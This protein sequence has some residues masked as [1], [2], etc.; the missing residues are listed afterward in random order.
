MVVAEHHIAP[1]VLRQDVLEADRA[2]EQRDGILYFHQDA[3][4]AVQL[5]APVPLRYVLRVEAAHLL[6]LP[7]AKQRPLVLLG[8]QE[9]SEPVQVE[10]LPPR[11]T[12]AVGVLY[13]TRLQCYAQQL[14]VADAAHG[15][16]LQTVGEATGMP[17]NL[18]HPLAQQIGQSPRHAMLH[19]RCGGQIEKGHH[20][21]DALHILQAGRIQFPLESKE[22]A[23]HQRIV[24]RLQFAAQERHVQAGE[25]RDALHLRLQIAE[26]PIERLHLGQLAAVAQ[27]LEQR[28]QGNVLHGIQFV[29]QPLVELRQQL[30]TPDGRL[31]LEEAHGHDAQFADRHLVHAAGQIQ[32]EVEHLE[33][34]STQQ[35]AQEHGVHQLLRRQLAQP[36]AQLL[37]GQPHELTD[38][39]QTQAVPGVA[40]EQQLFAG[41]TLDAATAL[42]VHGV[43]Q[44]HVVARF[45]RFRRGQHGQGAQRA[46]QLVVREAMQ[47]LAVAAG[48][49]I[50]PGIAD[51]QVQ[52]D[53]V[54]HQALEVRI[55]F[56]WC[57]VALWPHEALGGGQIPPA[58][59]TGRPQDLVGFRGVHQDAVGELIFAVHKD[60]RLRSARGAQLAAQATR[61]APEAV[62]LC[63]HGFQLNCKRNSINLS[64]F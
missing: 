1:I 3:I 4:G 12:A 59:V 5:E 9:T 19:S 48:K 64:D 17:Q 36:A 57:G 45:G 30:W 46:Q 34:G 37:E 10:V 56:G 26:Q 55:Q 22:D 35:I 27:H 28:H 21:A 42:D 38:P 63:P 25:Q 33:D 11:Q 54:P 50:V 29:G 61:T 6:A 31:G 53:A 41:P 47:L 32:L 51:L 62:R 20:Q 16:K 40:D 2:V 52:P 39:D 7:R 8:A 24:A 15:E 58:G 14:Q 23:F 44:L 49:G 18:L 43:P 13:E 60:T